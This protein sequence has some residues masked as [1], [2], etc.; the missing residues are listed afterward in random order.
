MI[1]ADLSGKTKPLPSPS[2]KALSGIVNSREAELASYGTNLWR[3]G[4][5]PFFS[6][7]GKPTDRIETL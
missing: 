6:T 4:K 1:N 2:K 5:R 3:A 7:T